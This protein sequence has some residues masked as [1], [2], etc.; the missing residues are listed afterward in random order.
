[1]SGQAF[2]CSSSL[3]LGFTI[4]IVDQD[5]AFTQG[6]GTFIMFDV[7]W[8]ACTD[9][10][11]LGVPEGSVELFLES[12]ILINAQSGTE[13]PLSEPVKHMIISAE[14]TLLKIVNMN[15]LVDYAIETAILQKGAHIS[16]EEKSQYRSMLI[17]TQKATLTQAVQC[18]LSF[19]WASWV[20]LW[21]HQPV[22]AGGEQLNFGLST[23]E[24]S[25]THASAPKDNVATVANLIHSVLSNNADGTSPNAASPSGAAAAA[26]SS[27]ASASDRLRMEREIEVD[28]ARQEESYKTLFERDTVRPFVCSYQKVTDTQLSL[29]VQPI[30]AAA[31]GASSPKSPQSPVLH[32]IRQQEFKNSRHVFI[33]SDVPQSEKGVTMGSKY[34]D[35][36]PDSDAD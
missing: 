28:V 36:K 24:L 21:C 35:P 11:R 3:S 20:Q 27:A 4:K 25:L 33:W 15:E 30:A 9:F 17:H 19:I 7:R 29:H 16:A 1:M 14:G 10:A 23:V 31:N 5:V 8:R 18:D 34:R 2:F 6:L 22:V 13:E 26:A 32:Q 12:N